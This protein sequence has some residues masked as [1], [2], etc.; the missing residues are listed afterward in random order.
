M[1][2]RRQNLQLA[3]ADTETAAFANLGAGRHPGDGEAA[4]LADEE[5]ALRFRRGDDQ[6]FGL[7]SV[8][9]VYPKLVDVAVGR[10]QISKFEAR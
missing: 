5:L 4:S 8:G 6:A 3:R 7:L 2:P 9:Q 1:S 10:A